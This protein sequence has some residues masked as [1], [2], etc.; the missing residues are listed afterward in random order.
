MCTLDQ[1]RQR[2]V[3]EP[4][5]CDRLKRNGLFRAVVSLF[6]LIRLW[7]LMPADNDLLSETVAWGFSCQHGV[8][9]RTRDAEFRRTPVIPRIG[10]VFVLYSRL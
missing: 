9:T 4:I 3:A 1:G 8:S 7:E 5:T 6:R 2:G 10:I